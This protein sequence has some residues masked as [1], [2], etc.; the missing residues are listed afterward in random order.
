MPLRPDTATGVPDAAQ[1]DPQ[2]VRPALTAHSGVAVRLTHNWHPVDELAWSLE[3]RAWVKVQG[4]T[5]AITPEQAVY[6]P[7]GTEHHVE[8]PAEALL[9]PIFLPGV[10]LLGPS[11]H[12][13]RRGKELDRRAA[14]LLRPQPG[15]DLPQQARNFVATLSHSDA[16]GTPP[17]PTD[18]RAAAVAEAVR[19]RPDETCTLQTHATRVGASPRTLQRVFL[20]QTG[21]GFSQW[22]ARWRLS[23]ANFLLRDG[24][25]V[26]EAARACGY[27]PSAFIARYRHE[28]GVTPGRRQFASGE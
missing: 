7:A 23:W 15:A 13:I 2:I 5:L 8:V 4:R 11:A 14:P 10:H 24:L 3:G 17:W 20:E 21:L 26:A 19:L 22:R 27:T 1:P 16:E 25:S 6:I 12:Q 28:F 9:E 18:P